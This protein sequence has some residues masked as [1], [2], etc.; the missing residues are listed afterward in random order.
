[1]KAVGVASGLADRFQSSWDCL[2]KLITICCGGE[3]DLLGE[4]EVFGQIKKQYQE[5]AATVM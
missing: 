2:E 4:T 5:Q 1:M 3:S